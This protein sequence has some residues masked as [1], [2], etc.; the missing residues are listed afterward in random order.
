MSVFLKLHCTIILEVEGL[1]GTAFG[2]KAIIIF[3]PLAKVHVNAMSTSV[4]HFV[5]VYD[6]E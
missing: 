4:R 3:A 2:G 5:P 6:D 1:L